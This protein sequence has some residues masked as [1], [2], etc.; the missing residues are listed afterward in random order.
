MTRQ[1]KTVAKIIEVKEFNTEQLEAEVK[2]ARA[3][4]NTEEE[5]LAGL[6]REYLHTSDDFSSR[7]TTG[8]LPVQEMDLFYTYLKHLTKQICHQKGIVSIRTAELEEKQRAMVAAYQEQRLFEILQGKMYQ[9]QAKDAMRK[10]QKEADYQF[11]TRK[12]KA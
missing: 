7:Q 2:K 9:V 12:V 4:L 10:E 1:Q 8:T 5:N 3:R 6:E 11:L